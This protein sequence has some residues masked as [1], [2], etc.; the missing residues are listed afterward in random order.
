MASAEVEKR[1]I[2]GDRCHGKGVNR[3]G[4]DVH[5]FLSGLLGRRL[6]GRPGV[7]V[8]SGR[9]NQRSPGEVATVL[10]RFKPVLFVS[11]L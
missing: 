7:S 11:P 3:E 8:R 1:Y 4:V 2:A 6:F 10:A 9:A 5:E